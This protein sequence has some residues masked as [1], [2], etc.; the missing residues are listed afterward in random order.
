MHMFIFVFQVLKTFT[1]G[2]SFPQRS[3]HSTLV[4]KMDAVKRERT[5]AKRLLTLAKNRVEK[6]ISVGLS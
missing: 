2:T 4:A 1:A 5:T 3:K 6:A